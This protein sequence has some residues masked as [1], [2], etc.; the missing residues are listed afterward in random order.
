MSTKNKTFKQK[1]WLG[2]KEGMA[3]DVLPLNIKNFE[4]KLKVKVFKMIGAASVA[5]IVSGIGKEFNSIIFY[6]AIVI[7]F[8]YIFYQISISYF[9]IK[10]LK[11][12]IVTRKYQVRNSPV[13]V[14]ATLLKG[15]IVSLKSLGK[16]TIGTGMSFALAH[17]LDVILEK[18]GKNPF[19]IPTLKKGLAKA[20][21]NKPLITIT[22]AIGMKDSVVTGKTK[23][24]EMAKEEDLPLEILKETVN[25][26]KAN[27]ENPS[28]ILK[29]VQ[30]WKNQNPLGTGSSLEKKDED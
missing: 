25:F 4:Q 7:S 24:E 28:Q 27:K 11:H 6:L 13:D 29:L 30:E 2:I 16:F 12:I 14:W 19:F 10:Q 5:F 26:I 17:E 3:L 21:F 18:E 8:L 15:T 9:V 20:G 1:A 22:E 23:L